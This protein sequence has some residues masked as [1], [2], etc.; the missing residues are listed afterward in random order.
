MLLDVFYDFFYGRKHMDRKNLEGS[1]A[2]HS[3]FCNMQSIF[4]WQKQTTV[5]FI[6]ILDK[7]IEIATGHV[8]IERISMGE[9]FILH[10]I[11]LCAYLCVSE[12]CRCTSS[13]S[14]KEHTPEVHG[15]IVYFWTVLHKPDNILIWHEPVVPIF[16]AYDLELVTWK[17][18][19]NGRMR[20][21][22]TCH[23]HTTKAVI[24]S[25]TTRWETIKSQVLENF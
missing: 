17:F 13:A 25:C 9:N 14:E 22:L 19:R 5:E 4:P 18:L 1:L 7:T 3:L 8:F 21:H 24:L 11:F 10:R 6:F 12:E 16:L 20:L 2:F 15:C 23:V